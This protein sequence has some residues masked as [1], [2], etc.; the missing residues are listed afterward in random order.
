MNFFIFKLIISYILFFVLIFLYDPKFSFSDTPRLTIII[1]IFFIIWKL[2]SFI[3]N[4][5]KKITVNDKKDEI[6]KTISK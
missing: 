1:F 3:L 5:I 4:L 2:I 6:N